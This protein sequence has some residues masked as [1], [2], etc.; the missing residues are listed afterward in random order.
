MLFLLGGG[1]LAEFVQEP[2]GS[3]GDSLGEVFDLELEQFE[4]GDFSVFGQ[5]LLDRFQAHW[6]LFGAGGFLG[7]SVE[8]FA[9]TGGLLFPALALE[10]AGQALAGGA[11]SGQGGGV[12]AEAVV[13]GVWGDPGAE[14]VEIDV[15]GEEVEEAGE[16]LDGDA[17][18]SF[19]PEGSEA[20]VGLVEE[21]AETFL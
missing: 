18:E 7:R 12:A 5:H 20:V 2:F 8:V 11:G 4:G 14:G 19:G 9:V 3:Q 10:K 16:V 1:R 17:F 6:F 15:S 21:F 13:F